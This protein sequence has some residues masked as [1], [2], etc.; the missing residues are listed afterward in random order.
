MTGVSNQRANQVRQ[1]IYN[2][3]S[4]RPLTNY[5]N[6]AAFAQPVLGTLGNSGRNSVKGVETW[7]F[8]LSLSRI[9]QFHEA[10]ALELRF[11]AYNVTNSFRPLNPDTNLRRPSTFGVIR[12]SR[13]PRIM[14]FALK[15]RF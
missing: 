12:T 15:Y 7:Q 3:Q 10:Q 1:D 4:G 8:D 13:D 2:D 5:L 6:A 9:F 11:E 14:Q